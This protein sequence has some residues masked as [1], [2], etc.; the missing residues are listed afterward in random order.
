MNKINNAESD[1]RRIK[2]SLPRTKIELFNFI[3]TE[4]GIVFLKNIL[5]TEIKEILY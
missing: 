5:P 1:P 4:R 3:D 2:S